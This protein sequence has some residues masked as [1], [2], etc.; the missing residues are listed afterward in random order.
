MKESK[1]IF[2]F[3]FQVC[4]Y[5]MPTANP[6]GPT[7]CLVKNIDKHY[8]QATKL[9]IFVWIQTYNL[10]HTHHLLLPTVSYDKHIQFF[11]SFWSHNA[12]RKGKKERK[13]LT[14]FLDLPWEIK[15]KWSKET[16]NICKLLAPYEWELKLVTQSM[17]RKT[18]N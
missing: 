7:T 16:K 8:P 18:G 12:P 11:S 1:M 15:W 2:S 5:K 14:L 4:F 6:E 3:L 9:I 17:P 13:N 10:L